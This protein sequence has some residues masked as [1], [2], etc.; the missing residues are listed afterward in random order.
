MRDK[1][2]VWSIRLESWWETR[3][4]LVL[5]LVS[6]GMRMTKETHLENMQEGKE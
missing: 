4:Y 2:Y 3:V 6:V 5:T 1:T